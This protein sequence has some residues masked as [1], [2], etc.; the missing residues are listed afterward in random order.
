MVGEL[1]EIPLVG[2]QDTS[3]ETTLSPVPREL[4]N[5]VYDKQG[6]V[7]KRAGC[8]ISYSIDVANSVTENDVDNLSIRH[9][10]DNYAP[11]I[12]YPDPTTIYCAGFVDGKLAVLA[13]ENQWHGTKMVD[14]SPLGRSLI[15]TTVF[16]KTPAGGE[17]AEGYVATNYGSI[18]TSSDIAAC[19]DANGNV[20]YTCV[21]WTVFEPQADGSGFEA[22]SYARVL[23]PSGEWISDPLLLININPVTSYADVKTAV[24]VV[25]GGT[26]SFYVFYQS[27]N[28]LYGREIKQMG[29]K[30]DWDFNGGAYDYG[31]SVT[32]AASVY[33]FDVATQESTGASSSYH[34]VLVY[35]RAAAQAYARAYSAINTPVA[36]AVGHANPVTYGM[37]IAYASTGRVWIASASNT[38]TYGR[39][40][41]DTI[42]TPITFTPF[43]YCHEGF[44]DIGV[45]TIG[46][47]AVITQ[48]GQADN[49]IVQGGAVNRV[50]DAYPENVS[51][52][53]SVYA[54]GLY[55]TKPQ[56]AWDNGAASYPVAWWAGPTAC[57]VY[58]IGVGFLGAV[59]A[60]NFG[61]QRCYRLLRSVTGSIPVVAPFLR[62]DPVA[63]LGGMG[64]IPT[65]GQYVILV[66]GEGVKTDGVI[67]KPRIVPA[68]SRNSALYQTVLSTQV[69]NGR[70]QNLV[71]ATASRTGVQKVTCVKVNDVLLLSGGVTRVF[72]GTQCVELGLDPPVFSAD[73][74]SA[75]GGAYAV[76]SYTFALVTAWTDGKGNVLRSAPVFSNVVSVAANDKVTMDIVLP[77]STEP[78][79]YNNRAVVEIYSTDANGST[80]FLQDSVPMQVN[81]A[82]NVVFTTGPQTSAPQLYTMGG[83]LDNVPPPACKHIVMHQNR[84]VLLG[85]PFDDV[86]YSKEVVQNELPGFSE[87]LTLQ[88]FEG[89]RV[90][91]GASMGDT[92]VIFKEDGIYG[93]RG[94]F[95]D[96]TGAGGSVS[97]PFIIRKGVRLKDT[98]S[99]IS[100]DVGVFFMSQR[101]L[102]VLTSGGEVKI[103]SNVDEAVKVDSTLPTGGSNLATVN[104]AVMDTAN[105]RVM[106]FLSNSNVVVYD[107]VWGAWSVFQYH[108]ASNS[109]LLF[110]TAAVDSDGTVYGIAWDSEQQR[111][112][113]DVWNL[114]SSN[115][116]DAGNFVNMSFT[117]G[118][119][120][121]AQPALDWMRVRRVGLKGRKL[122]DVNARVYLYYDYD[123]DGDEE[124]RIFV[125]DTMGDNG[126]GRELQIV[127]SYQKCSS[128]AVKY[129]DYAPTGTGHVTGNGTGFVLQSMTLEVVPKQGRRRI[130]QGKVQ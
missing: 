79:T 99:V 100:T 113:I 81:T 98:A 6:G 129:V 52:R 120:R 65:L 89:G 118:F 119:L 23:G 27:S 47:Q 13:D 115:S 124:N 57:S 59:G 105:S 104:A 73:V 102:A 111:T 76:G 96:D 48:G 29:S 36:A 51:Q 110:H 60:Y 121:S 30:G 77:W 46:T 97:L 22:S 106:F 95:P 94:T 87:G 2:G 7:K 28:A 116:L 91:G 56:D 117:G 66:T 88:P 9:T 42:G 32:G 43:S 24:K 84:V 63:S 72:D 50:F 70:P 90:L 33:G 128:I 3:A 114:S 80:F 83:V 20:L 38:T 4:L 101:G 75:A 54:G 107:T 112:A 108:N 126:N 71:I 40:F 64:P 53:A 25:P 49:F 58:D 35:S 18:L 39:T 68:T 17:A 19:V 45:T 86:W 15:A 26:S 41:V 92:L 12:D 69:V 123:Y 14:T 82:M 130:P 85:T 62:M 11:G 109:S 8:A 67:P 74:A 37:A 103:V 55:L 16:A 44:D 93:L 21:V 127:P 34:A 5:C 78:H 125:S 122:T 10:Y 1:I 31:T 61:T